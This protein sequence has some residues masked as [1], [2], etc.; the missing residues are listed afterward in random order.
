ML[1][2]PTSLIS[3]MWDPKTSMAL[4]CFTEIL[5]M[6]WK[7]AYIELKIVLFK[8]EQKHCGF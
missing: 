4:G 5:H 1:L 3:V 2:L 8:F 7:L 6:K